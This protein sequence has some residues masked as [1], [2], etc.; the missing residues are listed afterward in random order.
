MGKLHLVLA[1]LEAFVHRRAVTAS[2]GKVEF[3]PR[4]VCDPGPIEGFLVRGILFKTHLR[5][6]LGFVQRAKKF[7]FEIRAQRCIS[8]PKGLALVDRGLRRQESLVEHLLAHRPRARKKAGSETPCSAEPA[9]ERARRSATVSVCL[10]CGA[11]SLLPNGKISDA[12]VSAWRAREPDG[13]T[14]GTST[15][16][17]L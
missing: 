7:S 15:Q 3:G 17:W 5:Q 11:A 9:H 14:S 8:L 6:S 12:C 2:Q 4:A 1:R 10:H 13:Q 16:S